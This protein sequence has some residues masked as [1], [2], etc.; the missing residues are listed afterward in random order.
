[1]R[2]GLVV[3]NQDSLVTQRIMN[4]PASARDRGSVLGW[5]LCWRMEGATHSGMLSL[6]NPMGSGT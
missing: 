4:L 2:T 3:C 5:E 6:E 1:M